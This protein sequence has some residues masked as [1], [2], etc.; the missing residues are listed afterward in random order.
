MI[1]GRWVWVKPEAQFYLKTIIII[2]IIPLLAISFC[3]SFN[4]E[5]FTGV[6]GI[7]SLL[8]SS[9]IF[10]IFLQILTILFFSEWSQFFLWSPILSFSQTFRN[11]SLCSNTDLVSFFSSW[12]TARSIFLQAPFTYSAFSFLLCSHYGSLISF[13][14]IIKVRRTGNAG[15]CWKSKDDLISDVLLWTPPH[16]RAKT[17]RSARTY[18][19]KLC[20]DTRCNP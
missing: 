6:W 7:I 15:H 8:W 14:K 19:Q 16:E 5:S 20:T 9:G 10:W 2:I 4:W 18:I 3:A 13:S 1:Y 17:W 12:S 11:R